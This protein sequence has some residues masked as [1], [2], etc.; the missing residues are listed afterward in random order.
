MWNSKDHSMSFRSGSSC[1][2]FSFYCRVLFTFVF[3]L[4]FIFP[5]H[6]Q[7][8]FY[9]AFLKSLYSLLLGIRQKLFVCSNLQMYIVISRFECIH[10]RYSIFVYN[11]LY[12]DE[13]G[14]NTHTIL[15]NRFENTCLHYLFRKR[16]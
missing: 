7:F 9:L 13:K 5:W 16:Q 14:E 12:N 1:S 11:A 3:I 10:T 8:G 6:C 2:I 4:S 15:K